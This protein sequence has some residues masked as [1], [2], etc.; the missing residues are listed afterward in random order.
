MNGQVRVDVDGNHVRTIPA[1]NEKTSR[2]EKRIIFS[3]GLV[4]FRVVLAF[5]GPAK[6]SGHAANGS[7]WR[8][9][10]LAMCEH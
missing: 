5:D 1:N 10:D 7:C 8:E 6:N 4:S 9:A 3:A 2:Q